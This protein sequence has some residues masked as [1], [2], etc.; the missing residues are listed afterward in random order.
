MAENERITPSSRNGKG[1]LDFA[2]VLKVS[3]CDRLIFLDLALNPFENFDF[4][5]FVESKIT[6]V[7]SWFIRS[8]D[9]ACLYDAGITSKCS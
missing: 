6:T 7:D 9:Q 1:T 5:I 3:P 8:I 2:V 4:R